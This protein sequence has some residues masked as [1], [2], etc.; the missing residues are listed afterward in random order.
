MSNALKFQREMEAKLKAEKEGHR[1]VDSVG[2]KQESNAVTVQRHD[3]H[4]IELNKDLERVSAI[5]NHKNRAPLKEKLVAKYADA[6][7]EFMAS[8][9]DYCNV[10]FVWV[11]VW[12]FDIGRIEQ[13]I[14]YARHCIAT[15]QSTP[16]KFKTTFSTFLADQIYQF[17]YAEFKA[18]HSSD[19]YFSMIFDDVVNGVLDVPQPVLVKY[20]KLRG[21]ILEAAD[22]FENALHAFLEAEALDPVRSQVKTRI[23][24]MRKQLGHTAEN[25]TQTPPNGVAKVVDDKKPMQV[26]LPVQ[27]SDTTFRSLSF[28]M[29]I[30]NEFFWPR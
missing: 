12:L 23:A 2:V 16:D 25:A 3:L 7:E 19:P 18:G 22:D 15:G 27:L 11:T 24:E 9:K 26:R 5:T 21:D 13:F 8:G 30:V 28:L 4:M 10:L 6:C 17:A 1:A 29:G 14:A 20:W